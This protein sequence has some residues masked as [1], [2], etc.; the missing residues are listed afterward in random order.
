[1]EID[2]KQWGYAVGAISV[3]LNGDCLPACAPSII[4]EV[5]RSA[6]SIDQQLDEEV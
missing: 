4:Q 1:M 3:S 6:L 5:K 2:F